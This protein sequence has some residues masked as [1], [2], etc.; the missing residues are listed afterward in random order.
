MLVLA[1]S[2][3]ILAGVVVVKPLGEVTSLSKVILMIFWL[4]G[5]VDTLISVMLPA[6]AAC[7]AKLKP[8]VESV[9]MLR[10]FINKSP[11]II[12]LS[13]GGICRS[14]AQR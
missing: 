2:K 3:A 6:K 4:S 14:A 11:L 9:L 10:D 8:M 12:V 7:M 13:T 5:R 1:K